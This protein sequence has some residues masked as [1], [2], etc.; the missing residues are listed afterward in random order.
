MNKENKIS[1]KDEILLKLADMAVKRLDS[2]PFV[3]EVEIF[4][5]TMGKDFQNR[6][7]PTINMKD[8]QFVVDFIQEE[9]DEMKAAIK[10][11]DIVEILDGILDI[12]Y[13]SLG[14]GAMS[15]GLKNRIL[16]AYAE[17]QAS[18]MSKI[19]STLEEAVET[20]NVRTKEQGEPCHY[21]EIGEKFVVYRSR[22]LKV[23]K[24]INYFRPN[25]RQFFTDEEISNC[26]E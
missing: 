19:C 18:N 9:L 16:P 21:E 6:K 24:S 11:G 12:T 2:V 3:D 17:V 7:T 22:D 23:Q 10:N 15:F 20:V 26:K 1:V 25:L 5:K 4:N 14:N 13:V 8:A